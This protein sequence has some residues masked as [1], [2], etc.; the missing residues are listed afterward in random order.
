[1]F[2]KVEVIFCLHHVGIF[3]C[4]P[5]KFNLN[6]SCI[7]FKFCLENCFFFFCIKIPFQRLIGILSAWSK[8]NIS[9]FKYS[10]FFK[11]LMFDCQK[12]VMPAT[13]C[14]GLGV[15]EIAGRKARGMIGGGESR[16]S[17]AS[18]WSSPQHTTYTSQWRA[19]LG[20]KSSCRIFKD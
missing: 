9:F 13:A 20:C 15:G 10:A 3:N 1:M 7:L 11:T 19:A 17:L 4:T 14:Q 6:I 2:I 5:F 18:H 8:D 16:P 12:W